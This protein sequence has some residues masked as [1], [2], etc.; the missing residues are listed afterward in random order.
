MEKESVNEI[1]KLAQAAKAAFSVGDTPCVL[2]PSDYK[3]HEFPHLRELPKRIA[4]DPNL[5]SMG[6]FLQYW[7]KFQELD[8]V[9]FFDRSKATFYAIFDYH[10][11]IPG[12]CTN[13]AHY[14]CPLSPQWEAWVKNSG[15]GMSQTEFAYHIE[16][17]LPDIVSPSG[18]EMLE[19]ALSLEGTTTAAWKRAQRLDNGTVQFQFMEE[20]KGSAG[21]E[22]QLA[23]PAS[24]SIGIPVFRGG[25]AYQIEVAFRYRIRDAQLS[26]SY[27]LVRQARIQ[28]AAMDD[29]FK[30][31]GQTISGPQLVEGCP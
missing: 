2:V 8:S 15:K 30:I 10:S 20:I 23:I 6:S 28:E 24:F 17:N 14:T 19:I 22:G 29:L 25:D 18:A 11:E 21:R 12:W 13:R 7:A 1:V 26:L 3:I 27:E 9:V 31:A 5:H 4:A 16:A